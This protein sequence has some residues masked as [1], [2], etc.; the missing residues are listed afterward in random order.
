MLEFSWWKLLWWGIG[1]FGIAGTIALIVFAPTVARLVFDRV[2]RLFAFVLSYRL[3]CALVA[4]FLTAI[5]VDYVRHD[6]D[7]EK[8]AAHI[9]QLSAEFKKA[10]ALRDAQIKAETRQFVMN[11]IAAATVE[12]APIDKDVKDFTD[13]LPKPTTPTGNLFR[14]GDDACRLRLIAG[15]GKAGCGSIGAQGVPK[16][17]AGP[18]RLRD[19]IRKRLSPAGGGSSGSH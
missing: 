14:V 17:D 12:N 5:V 10:Q 16:A 6:I 18:T 4:T 1:T 9:E 8:H 11:E 3:G 13:A 19:R 15:Q 7:D 2:V